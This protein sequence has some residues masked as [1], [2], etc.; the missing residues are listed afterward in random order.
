MVRV[1]NKIY[2]DWGKV[3]IGNEFWK[4]YDSWNKTLNTLASIR[5]YEEHTKQN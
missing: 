4:I 2:P 1:V 3:A 5:Y